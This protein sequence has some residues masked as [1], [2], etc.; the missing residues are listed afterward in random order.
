MKKLQ[1]FVKRLH[2]IRWIFALSAVLG[3]CAMGL[4]L[5]LVPSNL[6]FALAGP[7]VI[8]PWCLTSISFS[9]NPT[10]LSLLFALFGCGVGLVW[11]AIVLLG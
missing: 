10:Y 11:P 8:I 1:F 5:F 9:R 6:G 3:L 7:L 4:T 2:Q